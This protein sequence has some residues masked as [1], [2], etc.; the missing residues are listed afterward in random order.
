M[1]VAGRSVC[2]RRSEK[3]RNW[4]QSVKRPDGFTGPSAGAPDASPS[5][6]AVG[7]LL[8]PRQ[9]FDSVLG[10]LGLSYV[11]VAVIL[12]VVSVI[13]LYFRNRSDRSSIFGLGL[14][15]KDI[16]KHTL[17]AN[18]YVSLFS[19]D[20]NAADRLRNYEAVVRA[21]FCF[22]SFSCGR[23]TTEFRGR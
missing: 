8:T 7:C 21:L 17:E 15:T 11:H 2:G 18:K 14:G 1:F 16:Q 12:A 13:V 9:S 22:F 6:L 23:L 10:R 5:I 20:A 3:K 4:P 19:K